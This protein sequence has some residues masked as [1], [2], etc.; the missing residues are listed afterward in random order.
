MFFSVLGPVSVTVSG[1]THTLRR[2]QRRALLGFLLLN[3][4]R[5]VPGDALVEALWGGAEPA[6]SRAQIQAG[7]SALRAQLR[8]LFAADLL[9]SSPAGY[10]LH[11][12]D[13]QLD[14]MV[15][16]RLTRAAQELVQAGQP[17]AAA[18]RY[19]AGLDLWQGPALS[20]AAGAFVEPA[21]ARLAERRLAAVEG[22]IDLELERGRH[23]E[24]IGEFAALLDADPLRE[25]LRG[26]LMLALYRASRQAEALELYRSYVGMLRDQHGL[27]P[28]PEL[29]ALQAAILK[30]DPALDPT[31]TAAIGNTPPK[32]SSEAAPAQLPPDIADFTGRDR[33]LEQL[34]EAAGIRHDAEA[35]TIATISGTAGIGKTA[36]ALR[37]AHR[38]SDRFGDGQLYVNLHGYARGAPLRP[39]EALAQMLR[40]LGVSPER[41]PVDVEEASALYRSLLAGKRIL[42]VLDNAH[43]AEHVRPLLPGS[44]GCVAV[45]TSRDRLAGLVATHGARRLTLG[46]P[47]PDEA[48]TM[49]SR[50]V[51]VA[52]AER[53]GE[54][55]RSLAEVC[56]F[57]PLA[58]RIAGATL[59]CHPVEPIAGYVAGLRAGDR[60]ARLAMDG[61]PQ[62][63]V[64]AAFDDSYQRLPVD[65]R[66]LFRL[67]GLVPGPEVSVPAAAALAAVPLDRAEALLDA[68]DGAHLAEP[69]GR[70]RFALH[71][72]LR[73]YAAEQSERDDRE[74]ERAAAIGRL[75]SWYLHT[76][77]AA[78]SL[79]YA[80]VVRL[81]V[82]PVEVMPPPGL[83]DNAA[84]ASEWLDAERANLVAAVVHA[85]EHG[86]LRAAWL[87]ADTL[88][89]YF[90][91]RRHTVDWLA[92]AQAAL[93]AATAAGDL[94]GQAAA[95]FS[96][97]S[98]DL[99]TG[100]LPQAIDHYTAA[101]ALAQRAGWVEGRAAILG[102]LGGVY[103]DAGEL[104]RAADHYNQALALDR[105]T[106]WLG[107]QAYALGS[108][109]RVYREL[110]KLSMAADHYRQALELY[111]EIGAPEG[112]ANALINLGEVSNDLGLLDQATGHLTQSLAVHR[113]SGN[114]YGEACDLTA[115]A[116]VERDAGHNARGLERA[117]AARALARDIGD[118]RTEAEAG[119]ILA[120]I[121]L[122][123]GHEQPAID[124]LTDALR[125]ARETGTRHAEAG[126]LLSLAAAHQQAGRHRAAIEHAEQA[127]SL[128]RRAG[129]GVLEGQA[130]T[131]LAAAELDL[132]HHRQA[133]DHARQAL[134]IQR[135]TGHRLGV[136]HALVV[137]GQAQWHLE[138]A[139]TAWPY[140]QEALELL[141]EIG[142]P[143]ARKVQALLNQVSQPSPSWSLSRSKGSGGRTRIGPST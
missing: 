5:V 85:A 34:G 89:G 63:T 58:L 72:L 67:L 106:G 93:A 13:D 95:R 134:S 139:G 71:D 99:A 129:F 24:V 137:L 22:L 96:L 136:A 39:I 108:L 79:L 60:L 141:T 28:G 81:P 109:G 14:L 87:L 111:R 125:L 8:E 55:M 90:W 133:A 122:S 41:I 53:E 50:I 65:V 70:G 82:P 112:E 49:L 120:G 52:R 115:L 127:L 142:T 29:S 77:D 10:L 40:G 121:H 124:H 59:A 110:G 113:E 61:D 27:D 37:W 116:A 6:T 107:G 48:V 130:R 138:E 68:L 9:T 132:G 4:N 73:L 86:H 1:R 3:A 33:E 42:V 135:E 94:A 23:A 11:V 30:T 102:Y 47:T 44:R 36:L 69:H 62:A 75:L 56:G 26:Q 128:A 126:A 21:R 88:R 123:M 97:G 38:V 45:I 91:L 7:V 64:R 46:V 20:G 119:T 17:A 84:L 98:A 131:A 83:G 74:P 54:A 78:A 118:R 104:S 76:A 25:R 100:R 117:S 31:H 35:V 19:R 66:R 2:A 18:E 12:E 105:H 16:E 140:W 101:G 32:P 114:R 57:L 15:F 103:L 51:G 43:D 80:Q 143:D 92:V